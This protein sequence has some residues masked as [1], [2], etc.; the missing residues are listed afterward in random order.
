MLVIYHDFLTDLCIWKLGII[1]SPNPRILLLFETS[2]CIINIFSLTT[3]NCLARHYHQLDII[4]SIHYTPENNFFIVSYC[5]LFTDL[6]VINILQIW[7]LKYQAQY[8]PWQ[9]H[10]EAILAVK[11]HILHSEINIVSFLLM[12]ITILRL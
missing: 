2:E 12:L 4:I 10:F 9:C 5:F 1:K 11:V 6:S 7:L 8:V 3:E